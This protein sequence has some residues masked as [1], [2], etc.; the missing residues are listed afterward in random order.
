[1]QDNQ[2]ILPEQRRLSAADPKLVLIPIDEQDGLEHLS[3]E[4]TV[5]DI[6][7]RLRA[8]Q[9]QT[10]APL[11]RQQRV[12]VRP[13]PVEHRDTR[14]VFLQPNDIARSHDV[15]MSDPAHHDPC[16]RWIVDVPRADFATAVRDA[17]G[18]IRAR[19]GL[20]PKEAAVQIERGAAGL[21]GGEYLPDGN[22][23]NAPHIGLRVE[24]KHHS[25]HVT[26]MGN[27][28]DGAACHP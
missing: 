1:M 14:A 26:R 2:Q 10:V 6:P 11:G 25:G 17:C 24:G 9:A 7:W 28:G 16:R 21:I 19:I 5:V 18:A 3:D 12:A 4:V 8:H 20:S 22:A 13:A 15:R 23:T 27:L